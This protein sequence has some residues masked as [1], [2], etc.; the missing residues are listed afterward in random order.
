MLSEGKFEYERADELT[1]EAAPSAGRRGRLTKQ[2]GALQVDHG[3]RIHEVR[4]LE[5]IVNVIADL[6][7][8][9]FF[10]HDVL[11]Q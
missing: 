8:I 4:L 5:H 2:T 9:F 10:D 3:S 11:S 7:D 6:K 1:A